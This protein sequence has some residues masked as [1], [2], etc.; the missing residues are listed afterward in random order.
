VTPPP[1]PVEQPKPVE[2]PPKPVE[3]PKPVEKPAAAPAVD[4][5]VR[6]AEVN[7]RYGNGRAALSRQDLSTAIREFDAV[8]AMDPSHNGARVYRQQAVE[9]QAKL[10]QLPPK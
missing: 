1:K 2:P 6:A 8:L 4:P 9:L 5:K 7:R 3:A 10:N